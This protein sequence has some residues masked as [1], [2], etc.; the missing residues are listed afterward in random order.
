MESNGDA[1]FVFQVGVSFGA[2]RDVAVYYCTVCTMFPDNTSPLRGKRRASPVFQVG[3]SFGATRELAFLHAAHG[4]RVCFPQ[5]NGMLFRPAPRI[6]YNLY[7]NN[8][9]NNNNNNILCNNP[10][11]QRHALQARPPY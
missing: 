11:D 4:G 2:T 9:N 10:L 7:H 5:T 6:E 8:N 3:V 1:F